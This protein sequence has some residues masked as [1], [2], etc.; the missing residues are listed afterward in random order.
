MRKRRHA[1][2]VDDSILRVLR[3]DGVYSLGIVWLPDSDAHLFEASNT[4]YVLIDVDQEVDG[5]CFYLE[6]LVDGRLHALLAALS[7]ATSGN[8]SFSIT[9]SRAL[10]NDRQRS[11]GCCDP[12]WPD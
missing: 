6:R 12:T 11:F 10:V 4:E 2:V 1:T 9:T 3:A 5:T 7:L 8:A